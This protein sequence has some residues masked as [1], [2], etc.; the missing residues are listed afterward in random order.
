VT[1]RRFR[2]W[3]YVAGDRL[4]PDMTFNDPGGEQFRFTRRL[5][6][7]LLRSGPVNSLSVA[8]QQGITWVGG[9]SRQTRVGSELAFNTAVEAA[10]EAEAMHI[11]N[12]EVLPRYL[13]TVCA[14][15]DCPIYGVV[16]AAHPV[17]PPKA[18]VQWASDSPTA[19]LFYWYAP[20]PARISDQPMHDEGPELLWVATHDGVA[21]RAAH[22]LHVANLS[23]HS[24]GPDSA[25][26][27][28]ILMTY[29][30]VLERIA[31]Q[32]SRLNPQPPA[33][34]QSIPHVER[35]EQQLHEAE[36][37]E[38]KV[39]AVK[40]AATKLKDLHTR[41]MKRQVVDA[42][43]LLGISTN[44]VRDAGKFTTLRHTR[45]AHAS[46]L[47][48][49]AVGREGLDQRHRRAGADV[50]AGGRRLP[51]VAAGNGQADA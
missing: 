45:L 33:T 19:R 42:G 40:I 32:V 29:Y 8:S 48:G 21:R 20:P 11:V 9:T 25:D 1:T 43:G 26:A 30:F 27:Q 23:L 18:D 51:T 6:Q 14:I 13:A 50:L 44:S 10:D 7:P 2:V 46:K 49:R 5:P 47:G 22:D 35:L 12:D 16:V 41:G 31:N 28:S 4:P 38:A 39:D 24:R 15:A 36:T 3:G 37:V 34:S 17:A